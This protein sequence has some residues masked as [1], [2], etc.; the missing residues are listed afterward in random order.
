MPDFLAKLHAEKD[1]VENE[2]DDWG[3]AEH[4]AL[5]YA[6]VRSFY[7]TE[8]EVYRRLEDVQGKDV[9]RLVAQV[10]LAHPSLLPSSPS[11]DTDKFFEVP[12]ILLEFIEGFRRILARMPPEIHGNTSVK[13]PFV[14]STSSATG[15]CATWTSRY[16]TPPSAG[17]L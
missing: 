14:S 1:F 3:A 15:T 7:E 12:G 11:R 5:A 2:S 4:E 6:R 13:M 8:T 9:P 16:G 10:T 17:T